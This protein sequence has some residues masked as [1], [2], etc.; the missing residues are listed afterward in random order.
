[1]ITIGNKIKRRKLD[2][3]QVH[4]GRAAAAIVRAGFAERNDFRQSR[5][6]GVNAS[7]EISNSFAVNDAHLKNASLAALCQICGNE[8]AQVRRA[9]G[10]Q[11]EHAVDGQLF[12][13]LTFIKHQR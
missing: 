7:F 1:M 12:R 6:N 11:V 5:E 13:F 8:F 10:V 9:K 3:T 2:G 4:D